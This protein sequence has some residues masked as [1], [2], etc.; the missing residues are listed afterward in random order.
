ME[1]LEIY[2]EKSSNTQDQPR[3][4]DTKKNRKLTRILRLHEMIDGQLLFPRNV[5]ALSAK[6][7]N[8]AIYELD[9]IIRSSR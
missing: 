3:Q 2:K 6:K 5:S 1:C 4:A 8:S 7:E 9:I